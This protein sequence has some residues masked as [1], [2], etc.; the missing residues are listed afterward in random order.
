MYEDYLTKALAGIIVAKQAVDNYEL[1]KIKDIKNTAA[2]NVQ[3]AC[4]YIL[5]YK[6]YNCAAYNKG[7]VDIKQIYDHD[8]DRMIHKFCDPYGIDVPKQIR[9]NAAKYTLWEAESR[10]SLGFSI[11][12]DQINAAICNVE[13]WLLEIK[14]SYKKK[15]Q[16]VNQR[17]LKKRED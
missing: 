14:P 10:Y 3:Q 4:E 2:F 6:I 15:L 5:K 1:T 17:L 9:E 12:V 13:K 11:R 16:L 8:L 7:T